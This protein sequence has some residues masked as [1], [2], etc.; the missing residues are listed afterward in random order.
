MPEK[1]PVYLDYLD[2][3]MT[4]MG[5]LSAF[6]V[7]VPALVVK[8][9]GGAAAG[10]LRDLWTGSSVYLLLGC[11]ALIMGAFF[12]YRQRS[13]LA[14]YYGQLCLVA[15]RK[16]NDGRRQLW[17]ENADSW[18]TWIYYR[19]AFL[20][21]YLGFALFVLSVAKTFDQSEN[22]T[23]SVLGAASFILCIV[24][25]FADWRIRTWYALADEPWSSFIKGKKK[26]PT[27]GRLLQSSGG[28]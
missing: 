11:A 21:L 6:S 17:L 2:K 20:S 23:I 10:W 7:A 22:R 8:E 5:L 13:L 12:F 25:G 28:S 15:E 9:V 14:W 18:E 19:W 4:I 24:A 16:E 27:R 26:C 1:S 3:E